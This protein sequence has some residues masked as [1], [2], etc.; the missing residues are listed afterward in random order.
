MSLLPSQA[1][2][3][4]CTLSFFLFPSNMSHVLY[5]ALGTQY[6]FITPFSGDGTAFMGNIGVGVGAGHKDPALAKELLAF[7]SC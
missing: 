5:A 3:N 2:C 6:C 4:Q 7:G 1:S